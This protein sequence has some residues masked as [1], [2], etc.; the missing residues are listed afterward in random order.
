MTHDDEFEPRLGK[1]A[2]RTPTRA[3]T[4]MQRVLHAAT[5]AGP[6]RAAKAF[7]GSR[8]GRGTGA[9][10][11]LATRDAFSAQ[12]QR[13]VIVKSRIVKLA[14]KGIAAARAH[15]RYIQRD[16][17]TR[18][19]APGELYSAE[20]D[21]A[22]GKVFLEEAADDRHQ[23][24]FIVSAEDGAEYEDLRPFVRRWMAQMEEDLGTKLDWVAVDHFNT[25]HPHSH[26]IV[27]GKDDLGKDLI[28]GREYMAH[29]MR[30]RAAEIVSFDLGP[31]S[32]L[33]ITERLRAQTGMES[34]TSI[35]R[36]L[37]KDAGPAL[38]VAAG[39]KQL[40]ALRQALRAGRLQKLQRMG[41]A[42]ELKPGVWQISAQLESTLRRMGERGDIIK[43][44][45]RELADRGIRRGVADYAIYDPADHGAPRLVGRVVGRGLSDEISDHHYAVIDGVDGRSHYVDL[46]K[47]DDA[48]PLVAGSVVAITANRPGARAADR[49]VAEI[50]AAHD[51]RYSVD[52]HLAHDPTATAAFAEAHVR[53]LEAIR[54]ETGAVTREKDG[55]WVVGASHLEIAADYERRL[56]RRLPVQ[57]ETLSVLPIERQRTAIGVT[58]LDRE[59]TGS[60]PEVV[61]D[62]GFGREVNEALARRRQWLIEQDLAKEEGAQTI[63]RASVLN[64]LRR[65]EM[66]NVAGQLSADL[67]SAYRET[68]GGDRVEG[69]YRR[70]LDLVSGKFALIEK[71]RE[72]TLVPWRPMLERSLGKNVSGIVRGEQVSWTLGRQRS[73]P[74]V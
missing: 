45:H 65:R 26:V 23:F 56:A 34:F 17:V 57:V 15:L 61:R 28:I 39:A 20:R 7:T 73:G 52:V 66:S 64:L 21:R 51:G 32:D 3:R 74:E 2:N 54:R 33:E 43:T 69:V 12:R 25:G 31:R 47:A 46:G 59:L 67:G 48:D 14:G 19:G 35:D 68:Q 8:I 49:T 24:R 1:I 70:S 16:G 37:L 6:R 22:D 18:Q 50:A 4:Y 9:G 72:F 41:L 38:E 40:D 60:S 29:G 44:M 5:L 63:Y 42:D 11:V 62:A 55:M 27:R 58:W 10:R 71:S 30:E 53:R 13:R 36:S